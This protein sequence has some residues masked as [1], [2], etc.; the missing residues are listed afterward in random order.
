[1]E[2]GIVLCTAGG[3]YTVKTESGPRLCRLRG[4]HRFLKTRILPGDK[5]KITPFGE[6]EGVIEE[7]FPRKTEL[8]RPPVANVEQAVI[9]F[10]LANPSPSL[11][12]LDR[13]IILS[14]LAKLKVVIC[15]NK[16]DL[17]NKEEFTPLFIS[18]ERAGYLV[19]V[20]SAKT[21][22]GKEELWEALKRKLSVFA[23]PSG[24]GKSSLLN[25]LCPELEL[26]TGELSRKTKGGRHTTRRVELLELR[27]NTFVIDTPGFHRLDLPPLSKNTLA[28][29]FPELE[30]YQG[31]CSF[32]GCLHFQEPG[33]QVKEAVA[34][35]EINAGR[36]Q[37]YTDFLKELLEQEKKYWS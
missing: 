27:E 23:G 33:C 25:T 13:L 29:L 8:V 9:I 6:K 2:T 30:V 34:A 36:Y 7:V 26:K 17:V 12:L 31:Q 3:F 5:V 22:E 32:P 10:A 4:K 14:I 15:F 28:S 24:V 20:T 19:L 21:G 16:A 35:G 18:Y 1:M 11:A 37:R